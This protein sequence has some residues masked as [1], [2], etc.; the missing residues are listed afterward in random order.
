MKMTRPSISHC[1]HPPHPPR[2]HG[3]NR[4]RGHPSRGIPTLS[5]RRVQPVPRE[6]PGPH[7]QRTQLPMHPPPPRGA[8]IPINCRESCRDFRLMPPGYTTR[9]SFVSVQDARHHR[10]VP[11]PPPKPSPAPTHQHDVVSTLCAHHPSPTGTNKGID[12]SSPPAQSR[13][14]HSTVSSSTKPV[15][16]RPGS[17]V[18]GSVHEGGRASPVISTCVS[19]PSPIK[20]TIKGVSSS[21]PPAHQRGEHSCNWARD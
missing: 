15:V 11:P 5:P 16:K 12:S 1:S 10:P 4:T 7:Q 2:H 6:W 13:G 17:C 21:P 20:D 9:H 8:Y 3:G 19:H 14:E 18:A